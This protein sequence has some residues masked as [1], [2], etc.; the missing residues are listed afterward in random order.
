MEENKKYTVLKD[1]QI[2]GTEYKAGSEIDLG[3][4]IAGPLVESGDIEEQT[5]EESKEEEKA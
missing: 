3:I 5:Q 1:V 2:E 4:N